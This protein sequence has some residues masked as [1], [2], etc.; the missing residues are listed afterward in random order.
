MQ[1][2]VNV[3]D[4]IL[5]KYID[6]EDNKLL[7]EKIDIEEKY[8][9]IISELCKLILDAN[10]AGAIEI[11]NSFKILTV[12]EKRILIECI[13][14]R[15]LFNRELEWTTHGIRKSFRFWSFEQKV[16]YLRESSMILDVLKKFTPYVSYGFG[17]VLGFVRD[18]GFI[19]HDDD[20]DIIIAL[21]GTNASFSTS[22][23]RLRAHLEAHGFRCFETKGHNISHIGVN[24]GKGAAVDVFIGFFDEEFV[25]WFPSA[26]N[27]MKK[28]DVF[29]TT[30]IDILGVDCDIPNDTDAYL[31]AT[32]GE[33]WKEPI[34]NWHHPWDIGQYKK[35]L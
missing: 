11:F 12:E 34:A 26:V 8:V 19:P 13:N 30:V 35:Y 22:K 18:G 17:T 32:Y 25:S 3:I 31:C 6:M 24:N 9:V 27:N 4:S 2:I 20:I 23:L 10:Y 29:P 21:D 16:G 14:K 33:S 1:E 7:V 5:A 28:I 15:I